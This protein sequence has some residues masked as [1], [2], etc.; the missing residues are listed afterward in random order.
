MNPTTITGK[1]ETEGGDEIT[2]FDETNSS[3]YLN[4]NEIWDYIMT[5]WLICNRVWVINIL[6]ID[7]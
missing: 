3:A 6:F 1:E 7:F 4:W 5:I 2:N